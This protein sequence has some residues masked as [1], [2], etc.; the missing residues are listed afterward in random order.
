M[1]LSLSFKG[2]S[3]L[4]KTG[5]EKI[6]VDLKGNLCDSCIF[7]NECTVKE[8]VAGRYHIP[9]SNVKMSRCRK[10]SP[11]T[12]KK[13]IYRKIERIVAPLR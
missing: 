1:P 5:T 12:R 8:R 2:G 3:P 13:A 7:S 11:R 10:F 6:P 9:V 4:Q